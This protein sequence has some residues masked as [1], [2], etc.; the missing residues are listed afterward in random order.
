VNGD[1]CR[2]VSHPALEAAI[3]YES[4]TGH[5]TTV[6][7]GGKDVHEALRDAFA[8]HLLK[9]DPQFERVAPRRFLLDALK[10]V[11]VLAPDAG[12][13]VRAVRV[14]KLK[15]APPNHGGTLVVEAPGA[16]SVV[17]VYEL[18][19]QW[20]TEQCRLF[21][22]FRVL[23][24][25]ISIHLQPRPNQRKNKTINLEL[26]SPNGS[27]LKSLIQVRWA[28]MSFSVQRKS[29]ASKP[30]R[31]RGSVSFSITF[32]LSAPAL[33]VVGLPFNGPVG[34][35]PSPHIRTRRLQDGSLETTSRLLH[36]GSRRL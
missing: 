2:T 31:T 14:R 1:F 18:G 10:T 6:A 12:L 15:L 26:T 20:F 25:T 22:K 23:Q 17:G 16:N 21:E 8:E 30:N 19:D 3:M 33:Q 24:A 34:T 9:V 13:G 7:K 27:N 11:Q 36:P 35:T 29:M 28:A 4:E 32:S 5:V